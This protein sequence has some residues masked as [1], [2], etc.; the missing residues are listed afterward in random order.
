MIRT[1][2]IVLV[3]LSILG[4]SVISYKLVQYYGL[5][6]AELKLRRQ[7]RGPV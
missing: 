2:F 4:W 1:V 7:L 6:K 3:G 5:L